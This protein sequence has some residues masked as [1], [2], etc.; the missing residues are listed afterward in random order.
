MQAFT[1]SLFLIGL[2][3]QITQCT[4]GYVLEDDYNPS[5]FFSMFSFFTAADPTNGFVQYVGQQTAQDAGLISTSA[6][7]VYIG[8]DKDNAA[9]DGRPSVRLTSNKAYN[10]GLIV[11]D[12]EHMP[13]G[14]G[15]WPAFWTVGPSWPN[16]YFH[17]NTA[18]QVLTDSILQR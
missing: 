11:L 10:H 5:S 1:S 16:K 9:P 8:V 3:T 6:N 18:V 15:T 14:C 12:L 7:T 4:A 17:F 13:E 2:A